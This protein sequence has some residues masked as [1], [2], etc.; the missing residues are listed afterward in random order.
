MGPVL[1]DLVDSFNAN[2]DKLNSRIYSFL[3][4]AVIG[5]R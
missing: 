5:T 3:D 4:Y 2:V 1:A